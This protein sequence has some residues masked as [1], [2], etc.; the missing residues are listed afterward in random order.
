[1]KKT[2]RQLKALAALNLD[3]FEPE[4]ISVP[5]P[6]TIHA[7]IRDCARPAAVA[8]S[9][10]DEVEA[11][12]L[13][14]ELPSV[15]ELYS[16]FDRYNWM[17]FEGALP[18]PS[19]EY[20]PRMTSAGAYL[21]GRRL[22]RM[23]LKY[24]R[25]FPEEI[26]DTLKH[27]MIHIIHLKHDAAFKAE[28][29]RIGASL[30]AKSHPSLRRPPRYIYVCD[31]CGCEYPRQKRLRMASCGTCS[32]GGRYDRRFKLR[33]KDSANRRQKTLRR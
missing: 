11:P 32:T 29:S 2:K 10:L 17:Y 23:G 24:H 15:A 27:E 4:V 12:E 20:S 18:R 8:V 7:R 22:I 14:T 6:A 21:P 28:A 16:L 1:M 33:L 30:R 5:A 26:A 9:S 19:V 31:N 25:I 13:A 3:L